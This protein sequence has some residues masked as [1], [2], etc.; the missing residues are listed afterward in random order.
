[1]KRGTA[2]SPELGAFVALCESSRLAAR[3]GERLRHP[4][5]ST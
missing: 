1:M 5:I 4:P 2:M 3:T